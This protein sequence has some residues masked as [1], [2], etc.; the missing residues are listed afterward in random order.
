MPAAQDHINPATPMGADLIGGGVTI[1]FWAP[2][3]ERVHVV[4]GG[5][6]GYRPSP[7]DELV[8]DPDTGH[9]TGFFPGIGPGEKYRFL[10][11]GPGGAGFK[12]DPRAHELELYGYPDCDALV[13]DHDA[14]PWHDAD[15]RTPDLADLIVYQFHVGVFHATDDDGNDRRAK[16]VAKLLD[17]V[18]RVPYLAELGVNAVQPLPVVEFQGEWSLGYNGTD[19]FSPEMDYCVAPEDLPPY[20]AR[21]NALLSA[22]GAAALAEAELAEPGQP[23]QGVRGHLP[24]VRDRGPVR[25]GLQPRRRRPRPAEHRLHRPA[26]RA[27]PAQQRL[28]LPGRLGWRPRLRLRPDRGAPLSDRQRPDVPG[29]LPRGRAALRRG[30]GDRRQGRLVLLPGADRG[31]APPQAVGRADRRVLGRAAVARRAA[32]ARGDGLR[33]RLQRRPARHGPADPGRGREGEPA[34]PCTSAGSATAC[35]GHRER[36]TT[37]WRTTTSC[38]TWTTTAR[39]ASRGWR[40]PTTP[41]PGTPAAGRARRPVCC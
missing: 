6:D 27:R 34:R 17:A 23:A 31:A 24:P 15:F 30:V 37:A 36:R 28:L 11:H 22:R 38:W 9:W 35:A 32:P 40:T 4:F 16:R 21:V 25:R 14:Y 7:A 8:K 1:R 2:A 39:R 41:D 10:V 19:L 3:A 12:R 26:R 18:Q 5:V 20:L 13:V 29:P 33:H